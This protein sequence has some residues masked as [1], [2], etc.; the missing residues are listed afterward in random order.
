MTPTPTESFVPLTTAA[1]PSPGKRT[2]FKATVL[3]QPGQA[4]NFQSIANATASAAVTTPRGANCEPR[5]SVQR[6][7]NRVTGMQI[8]CSCGEVIELACVYEAAAAQATAAQQPVVAAEPI[9]IPEPATTPHLEPAK[10][11]PGKKGKE[12]GKVL[13]ASAAKKPKT[14]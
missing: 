3:S 6:D 5:V 2:E 9:A 4:K 11:A 10:A 12:A 1:P 8:Q 7:G 14:P 13:P